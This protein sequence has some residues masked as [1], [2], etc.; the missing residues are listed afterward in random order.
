MSKVTIIPVTSWD[1]ASESRELQDVLVVSCAFGYQQGRDRSTGQLVRWPGLPTIERVRELVS[2]PLLGHPKVLEM[3]DA[4]AYC[5]LLKEDTSGQLRRNSGP[6]LTVDRPRSDPDMSD[7]KNHPVTASEVLTQAG[8]VLLDRLMSGTSTSL[9]V[10]GVGPMHRR[11][12]DDAQLLLAALPPTIARKT[13]LLDT[14]V[15]KWQPAE[16]AVVPLRDRMLTSAHLQTSSVKAYALYDHG[17]RLR[18]RWWLS[19]PEQQLW[20]C[21]SQQPGPAFEAAWSVLKTPAELG[22]HGPDTPFERR[23]N[24]VRFTNCPSVGNP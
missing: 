2:L 11:L 24:P 5:A 18:D 14:G 19:R 23:V 20:D 6:I 17:A 15:S 8:A 16:D 4:V 22:L 12:F 13:A 7:S 21:R 10:S 3:P 1:S 9:L